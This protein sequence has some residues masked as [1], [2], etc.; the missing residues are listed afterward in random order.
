MSGPFLVTGATGTIGGALAPA[1]AACG[2]RPRL[3][4]RDLGRAAPLEAYGDLL[5]ADLADPASLGAAF[6][7]IEAAFVVAPP[8]PDMEA[9]EANAFS[10]AKAAGVRRI[11]YVSNFGA[12]QFEDDL[13]RAH[14]RNEEVLKASGVAW[15]ILRPTRFMSNTPYGWASVRDAGRLL[16]PV[17]AHRVR[18]VDPR[19]IADL[20]AAALTDPRH[21]GAVYELMSEALSGPEIAAVLSETLGRPVRFLDASESETRQDLVQSGLPDFI[22]DKILVYFRT[23]REGRWRDVPTVR[24]LLGQAPRSYA[25]WAR[26]HIPKLLS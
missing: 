7:G 16:E 20:A 13:F 25:A 17:G 14:G 2:V 12:D 24:D 10:A 19:D 6:E 5:L 4:V 21:V 1:L 3:L 11:V 22:A 9:L 8:G 26:E 15:T 18:L 23:V